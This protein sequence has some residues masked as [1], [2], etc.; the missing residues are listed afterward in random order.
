M[1]LSAPKSWNGKESG[2]AKQPN[3]SAYRFQI[4]KTSSLLGVGFR[5][6]LNES[7][8]EMTSWEITRP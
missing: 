1:L 3:F 2:N 8:G 4:T 7:G 5:V 6:V